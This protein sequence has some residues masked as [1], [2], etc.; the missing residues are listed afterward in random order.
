MFR[1]GHK[2]FQRIFF[3]DLLSYSLTVQDYPYQCSVNSDYN[4][5]DK[6]WQKAMK[7]ATMF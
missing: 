5:A 4:Y 3:P 6:R 1:V 7:Y 2:S